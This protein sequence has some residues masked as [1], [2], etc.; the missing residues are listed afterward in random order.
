MTAG[1]Q[2][3]IHSLCFC[4]DGPATR[5]SSSYWSAAA[6]MH[7][8][9]LR[10]NSVLGDRYDNC[11][12][13]HPQCLGRTVEPQC[14]RLKPVKKRPFWGSHPLMPS[15][16]LSDLHVTEF[17]LSQKGSSRCSRWCWPPH[18]P[19]FAQ[20]ED[21]QE[22][23]CYQEQPWPESLRIFA[24]QLVLLQQNLQCL[25]ELRRDLLLYLICIYS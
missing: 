25:Q 11:K 14:S 5:R 22:L 6:N 19:L 9:L 2:F 20:L 15:V 1:S 23:S 12:Q 7:L 18:R 17:Q 13:D 4:Y 24:G 3:L 16:L 8:K 21:N 10:G